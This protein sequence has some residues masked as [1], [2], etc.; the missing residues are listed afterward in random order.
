MV[1][2]YA[3]TNPFAGAGGD[4]YGTTYSLCEVLDN[5]HSDKVAMHS[6]RMRAFNR[7]ALIGLSRLIRLTT[8]TCLMR[9]YRTFFTFGYAALCNQS[10]QP[11]Y[12]ARCAEKGQELVALALSS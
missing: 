4:I 6:N 1:W 11:L 12:H 7:S 9:T 10:F 3:E 2:D 8:T 5:F